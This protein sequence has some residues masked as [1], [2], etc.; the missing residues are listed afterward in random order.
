[1]CNANRVEMYGP[2]LDPGALKVGESSQINFKILDDAGPGPLNVSVK[3]EL[4]PK[5]L[6]VRDTGIGGMVCIFTPR[7]TGPHVFDFK[8]G[9]DHVPGSPVELEVTGTVKRD[10]SRVK[11][12]GEGLEGGKVGEALTFTVTA[13]EDAG[14]GPLLVDASGPSEPDIEL[15]HIEAGKFAVEIQVHKHGNYKVEVYWGD[16][17]CPVPGSPFGIRVVGSD[18]EKPTGGGPVTMTTAMGNTAFD[19]WD[20]AV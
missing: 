20:P 10:P 2:A 13:A 18:E 3:A 12:E 1:M 14:P 5:P 17:Q 6:T 9:K 16:E 11:V 7:C 4:A 19:N 8:W 15:K